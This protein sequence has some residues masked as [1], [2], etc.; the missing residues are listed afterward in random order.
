MAIIKMEVDMCKCNK[1]GAEWLAYR[2]TGKCLPQSC[3]QCGTRHWNND[4]IPTRGRPRKNI[5]ENGV[6]IG[7]REN[8]PAEV[9]A[10]P[11]KEVLPEAA[12]VEPSPI[13]EESE[14][15]QEY[16]PE[17]EKIVPTF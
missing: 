6:K 11:E 14:G 7:V 16:P 10:S 17:D 1:C 9:K 5:Y 15:T 13:V 2:H 12:P 8:K 4:L 3:H